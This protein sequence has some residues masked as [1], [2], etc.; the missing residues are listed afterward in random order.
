MLKEFRDFINRG[1]LIDLAVAF[2]TRALRSRA[3]SRP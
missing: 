3:W 1:N 2:V